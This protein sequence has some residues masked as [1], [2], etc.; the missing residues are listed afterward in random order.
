MAFCEYPGGDYDS[1]AVGYSYAKFSGPVSGPEHKIEVHDK[2]GHKAYDYVGHPSYKF[3]YGVEDPKSHVSQKRQ[4]HR[5]GDDV[6]GEYTVAQP[7]GKIRMVKYSSDKHNGFTAEVYIDG[8]PLHQ[9]ALDEQQAH[10]AEQAAHLAEQASHAAEH[11]SGGGE[12]SS[13]IVHEVPEHHGGGGAEESSYGGGEETSS[14]AE[15]GH[16]YYWEREKEREK[17]VCGGNQAT[18]A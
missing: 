3:E 10:L 18:R 14:D 9:D 7:D 15:A 17:A 11:G 8:K 5:D 16:E 4:E 12:H 2:Y 6:H 1:H 13:H